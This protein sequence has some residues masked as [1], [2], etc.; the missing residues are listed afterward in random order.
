MGEIEGG[1]VGSAACMLP[2]LKVRTVDTSFRL[3]CERL[4]RIQMKAL[5]FIIEEYYLDV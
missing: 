3:K 5:D 1:L 4:I 2:C